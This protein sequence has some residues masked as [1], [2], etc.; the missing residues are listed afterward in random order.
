MRDFYFHSPSSL[1]EV[2]SLLEEHGENARPMAG[3]TA[4][5]VLMKQS[6]VEAE[7]LVSLAPVPE[8]ARRAA[9]P[10]ASQVDPL[11]DF[12]GSSEYKRDMAVVFTRRAVERVLG[13][14]T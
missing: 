12:R 4:L 10:V 5:I 8:P 2:F 11:D 7:H 13:L 1:Q 14:A 6:L 3:G 9:D